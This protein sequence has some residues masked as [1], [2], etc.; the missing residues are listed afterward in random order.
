MYSDSLADADMAEGVPKTSSVLKIGFLYDHVSSDKPEISREILDF[1]VAT[2][3]QISARN[4]FATIHGTLWYCTSWR[5][6]DEY[7]K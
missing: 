1:H 2:F 6:N 7:T 3:F 4:K 5:S